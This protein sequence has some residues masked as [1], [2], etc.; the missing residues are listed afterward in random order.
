MRPGAG[1]LGLTNENHPGGLGT[2]Y[3]LQ[4]M[5]GR[6]E[7]GAHVTRPQKLAIRVIGSLVIGT[8]QLTVCPD[9]L[10]HRRCPQWRQTL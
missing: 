4:S 6:L 8:H 7:V 5:F 9:V 3:G 10:K 1:H 2:V